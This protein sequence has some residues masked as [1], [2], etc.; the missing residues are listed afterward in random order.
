M[1]ILFVIVPIFIGA[2]FIYMIYN[3][4]KNWS[5]N[6]SQPRVA[7]EAI[8]TGKRQDHSTHSNSDSHHHHAY[9]YITFEFT[10]GD[11]KEFSISSSEYGLMA[12]GDRGMLTF[13]GNEFIGFQRQLKHG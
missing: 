12:E 3:F 9:Y 1:E 8:I 5:Y 2:V 13:Q 10:T 6:R 4:V 7:A 11:R